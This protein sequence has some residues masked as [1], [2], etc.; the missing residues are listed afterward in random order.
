MIITTAWNTV[1]YKYSISTTSIL[2]SCLSLQLVQNTC[3]YLGWRYHLCAR[4][5]VWISVPKIWK[6]LNFCGIVYLLV[7]KCE[8]RHTSFDVLSC[9]HKISDL[10]CKAYICIKQN[11]KQSSTTIFHYWE[12]HQNYP[13]HCKMQSEIINVKLYNGNAVISR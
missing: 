1:Q 7:P 4:Y 3:L 9:I 2:Q 12:L 11:E 10:K 8:W 13:I 6:N 5:W